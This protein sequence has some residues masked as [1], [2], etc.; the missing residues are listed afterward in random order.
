MIKTI[1]IAG[2]DYSLDSIEGQA[3]RQVWVEARTAFRFYSCTFKD[4]ELVMLEQKSSQRYTPRK[5]RLTAQRLYDIW[6]KDVVFIFE[7]LPY[8]ERNRLINQDVFFVVSG[9]YAFL[10]NLLIGAREA[11]PTK[12]EKLTAVAQWLLLAYLQ[13]MDVNHKT[14]K[15]LEQTTPF[16]YVTLTRAFRLLEGLKLC[17]IETGDDKFKR[18]VFDTDKK[19]LF[20]RSSKYFIHPVKQRWYCDGI[21]DPKQYKLAGISALSHYS[22]LNPDGTTTIALT[23]EQWKNHTE[24]SFLDANPIDGDCC[25]E[26]WQYQPIPTDNQYVDKLSLALSLQ[27]DHDPRVEKEVEL[28]IERIWHKLAILG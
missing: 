24:D 15:E 5:L 3:L 16:H 22:A 20:E 23:A 25:V 28:M 14:A 27:D 21:K 4:A 12:R 13:G 1:S 9:K 17:R 7:H 8:V 10:P 2:K 19:A 6:G 11:E 26:I 18:I